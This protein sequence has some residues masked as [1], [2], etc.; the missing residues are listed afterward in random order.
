MGIAIFLAG[1]V[2]SQYTNHIRGSRQEQIATGEK[3]SVHSPVLEEMKKCKT[4]SCGEKI[5]KQELC[6][7]HFVESFL[8]ICRIGDC[9]HG[10][11]QDGKCYNHWSGINEDEGL[12][13]QFISTRKSKI[14]DGVE[15]NIIKDE[16][17]LDIKR[18]IEVSLNRKVS[19]DELKRIALTLKQSN[20][21]S[22][23]RTFIGY[24]IVG[25]DKNNGYW[26]RTDF[27]PNLEV[28]IIGLSIEDEKALTKKAEQIPGRK[29][30]GS[31]LDDRPN[32]GAKMTLFYTNKKL[33][34]EST[35]S[36]G[37]S[38]IEEK[39]ERSDNRGR[40]IDDKGGNDFGDYLLINSSN[41]L[42]FWDEEGY[43]YTAK[44]LP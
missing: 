36:D 11:Y 5:D 14:P 8:G 31:W 13:T 43:F 34:L 6:S 42:E 17:R 19:R 10:K 9:M 20:T 18:S 39:I 38:R 28:R 27:K 44:S 22:Y 3:D 30:I 16:K 1:C 26:A 24:F 32:I 40:R 2:M 29:T 41:E 15:Y 37:S 12:S 7:T 25:E 4:A 35:Y 23:Q 33:F 21:K